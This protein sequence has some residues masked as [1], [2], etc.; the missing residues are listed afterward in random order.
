[1]ALQGEVTSVGGQILV[2]TWSAQIADYGRVIELSSPIVHI[3]S[4][5]CWSLE[6]KG[7]HSM[8]LKAVSFF[9]LRVFRVIIRWQSLYVMPTI[10][11]SLMLSQ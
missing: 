8:V 5:S 2:C 7:H 10:S 11:S 4:L 9:S 3:I 6:L 1:M